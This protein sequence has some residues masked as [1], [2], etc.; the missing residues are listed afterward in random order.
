MSTERGTA[1]N[2]ESLSD[3]R[4]RNKH[5]TYELSVQPFEPPLDSADLLS[6]N[7]AEKDLKTEAE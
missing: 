2:G 1:L 4:K 7:E 5:A 3:A 6:S